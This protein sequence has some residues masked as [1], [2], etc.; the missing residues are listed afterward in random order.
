MAERVMGNAVSTTE[1][2]ADIELGDG[3]TD[4]Q[5]NAIIDSGD[6]DAIEALMRG[7]VPELKPVVEAAPATKV[8]ESGEEDGAAS[9]ATAEEQSKTTDAD[10]AIVDETKAP[11]LSKDGKRTIPYEVLE[12]A[13]QR[14][15]AAAEEANSLRTKVAEYEGKNQKVNS[16]LKA[17]GIDPESIT[18]EQVES[19]SAEEM[20]QLEEIDPLIGKAVR[21]LNENLARTQTAPAAPAQTG[22]PVMDAITANTDLNSWRA[23]DPDRWDFAV[24]VDEKLKADPKFQSLPLS[25]RFAEAARRTRIAFGD[26]QVEPQKQ[27]ET[28]AEIAAKKVAAA[29]ATAVPRSL[30]SIGVTPTSERPLAEQLADLSASELTARMATMTQSQ[31]EE[32]L[33]AIG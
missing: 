4:E 33:G 26:E 22:N 25:E 17:K 16:F 27:T 20:Q 21:L 1:G 8:V 11:V 7:E 23:S 5:L 9:S 10:S 3:I 2:V 13:R 6:P 24:S 31:I 19:L 30:S 12:T 15:T 28:T 18:D 32:V 29:T 14:A